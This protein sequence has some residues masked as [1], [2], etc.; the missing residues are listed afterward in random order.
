MMSVLLF[1]CVG[2]E[3]YFKNANDFTFLKTQA[4]EEKFLCVFARN[5]GG[6]G[7]LHPVQT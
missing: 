1:A 5:F 7:F 4:P 6:G 2:I 3:G